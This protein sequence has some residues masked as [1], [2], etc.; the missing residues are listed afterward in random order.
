MSHTHFFGTVGPMTPTTGG[1][2][3]RADARRNRA[4]ILAAAATVFA[5][6]GA[7]AS[8]EEV[9]A[10]AGVAIGTV[11]R[12]LPTK[13]D[14]LR[15]VVMDLMDRLSTEVDTLVDEAPEPTALFTFADRVMAVAADNAPVFARLAETGTRVQVAD[16]LDRL[17]PAVTVL[18]DRARRAGVVR[19]DLRVD[20][21]VALLAA[22]CQEAITA[23]WSPPLRRRT[24]TVLCD[25]LRPRP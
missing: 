5:E 7:A 10:R 17:R 16:A 13:P 4:G 19:A 2:P 24:M 23:G 12:H 3:L 14:L 21:L 22:V 8:T 20:E 6:Q 11:F 25:G 18:L 1:R 9:A 15:A